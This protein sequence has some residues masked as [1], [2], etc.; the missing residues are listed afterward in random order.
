MEDAGERASL[1]ACE[2]LL[3]PGSSRRWFLVLT[4]PSSERIA[5][6]NLQRQGFR[7]YYPRVAKPARNRGR[8]VDRIVSLFPRYL[9]VQLDTDQQSLAPIRSTSGVSSLVCFGSTPAVVPARMMDDLIKRA[10]P[11]S[12]LHLLANSVIQR[13]A[14][15]SIVAG[16][17]EGLSGIFEREAGNDRVVILLRLLGLDTPVRVQSGHIAP[18][19]A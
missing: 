12:G 5:E 19:L 11:V 3:Q 13:G 16:A 4:K 8:W 15:V 14:R 6:S 17:F 10:D 7:V 18:A 9:F 2:S 1:V